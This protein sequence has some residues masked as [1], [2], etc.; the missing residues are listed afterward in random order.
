MSGIREEFSEA[1]TS[2]ID[3]KAKIH[4]LSILPRKQK[5]PLG[6]L[7]E[8]NQQHFEVDLFGIRIHK[9]NYYKNCQ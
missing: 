7:W 8:K 6:C 1:V 2:E 3:S 4:L 9:N 5:S